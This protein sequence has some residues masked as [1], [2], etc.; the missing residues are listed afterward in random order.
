M[1]VRMETPEKLREQMV[2]TK[3]QIDRTPI[4]VNDR[5]EAPEAKV[6]SDAYVDERKQMLSH[7]IKL[8]GQKAHGMSFYFAL[9]SDW[10]KTPWRFQSLGYE[11]CPPIQEGKSCVEDQELILLW[12]DAKKRQERIDEQAK[13]SMRPITDAQSFFDQQTYAMRDADGNEYK[14]SMVK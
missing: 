3:Q 6:I 14:V 1:T 12:I 4:N 10:E 11:L 8:L 9:K 5:K 7:V 2:R 13:E